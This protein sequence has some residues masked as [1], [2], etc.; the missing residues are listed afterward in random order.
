MVAREDRRVLRKENFEGKKN[1]IISNWLDYEE[2]AGA[3]S[4]ASLWPRH[5]NHWIATSSYLSPQ[6]STLQS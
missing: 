5:K 3:T 2:V 4:R 1:K 6:V